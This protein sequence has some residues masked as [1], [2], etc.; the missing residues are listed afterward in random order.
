MPIVL[1]NPVADIDNN[2]SIVM[3]W[4]INKSFSPSAMSRDLIPAARLLLLS[5]CRSCGSH[6]RAQIIA[7]VVFAGGTIQK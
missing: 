2:N 1:D 3:P 5:I 7:I 6:S 4:T